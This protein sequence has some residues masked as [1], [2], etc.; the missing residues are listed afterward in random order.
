MNEAVTVSATPYDEMA[1][2]VEAK[3]LQRMFQQ[4]FFH[5]Y[6]F[7]NPLSLFLAQNM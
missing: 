5:N 1:N 2:K 3:L 6:L 7:Y 4:H